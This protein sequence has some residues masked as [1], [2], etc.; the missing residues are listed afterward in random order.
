L[1]G[2]FFVLFCFVLSLCE[3]NFRGVYG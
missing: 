3:A 1:F 2:L